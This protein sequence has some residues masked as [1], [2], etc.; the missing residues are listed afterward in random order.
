MEEDGKDWLGRTGIPIFSWSS[1]ARGF[2]TG[3]YLSD[4]GNDPFAE[5]MIR[6]YGTEENRTRLERARELGRDKGGFS[7]VQIALA[8]VLHRP[9]SI[10]PIVGPRSR[11]ELGSCVRALDIVLD[12]S[13]SR[14]LDLGAR[15]R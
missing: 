10:V 5:N 11:E 8:W 14:W 4:P 13:E 6:I 1:Q 2:F 3:R 12:E 9:Y 15:S 7:A